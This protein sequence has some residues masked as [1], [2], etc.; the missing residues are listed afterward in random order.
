MSKYNVSIQKYNIHIN[1]NRNFSFKIKIQFYIIWIKKTKSNKQL[2]RIECFSKNVEFFFQKKSY[3]KTETSEY[4][5]FLFLEEKILFFWN[6]VLCTA[7]TSTR[8]STRI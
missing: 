4:I 2:E 5:F 1:T 6:F 3:K 8:H 7:F